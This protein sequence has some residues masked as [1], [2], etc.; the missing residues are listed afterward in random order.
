[1]NN[2]LIVWY[3]YQLTFR[4]RLAGKKKS[5]AHSSV[6]T[7]HLS[8]FRLRHC[9]LSQISCASLKSA[10]KSSPCHL[11]ELEL[12]YNKLQDSGVELL[13]ELLEIPQCR[14]ETLRSGASVDTDLTEIRTQILTPGAKK[15][16]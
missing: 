10:L 11:K 2:T 7:L 12:S 13:C 16:G 3:K 8:S 6:P 4:T 14:L 1:M 5:G 9:S 15:P